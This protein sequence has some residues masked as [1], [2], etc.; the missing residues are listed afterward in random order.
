MEVMVKFKVTALD[1][2][3]YDQELPN[4]MPGSQGRP[5]EV[6]PQQIVMAT[7]AQYAQVGMMRKEKDS[8]KYSLLPASQIKWVEAEIPPLLSVS[9]DDIKKVNDSR[10]SLD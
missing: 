1:G 7:F 8:D 6:P 5:V 3:V 2:T 10:I 4:V 9:M